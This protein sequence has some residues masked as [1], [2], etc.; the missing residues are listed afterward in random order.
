MKT[1]LPFLH[2]LCLSSLNGYGQI[3]QTRFERIDNF[4]SG[5]VYDIE[6]DSLGFLWFATVNGLFRYNGYNFKP[7]THND[8]DP[9]SISTSKVWAL[10]RDHKGGLWAG[11]DAG[12]D[13][14]DQQTYHFVHCGFT[15]KK[16]QK[17][18]T[19]I[20][21]LFEDSQNRF[22]IG[23][24]EGIYQYKGSPLD[25]TAQPI[26]YQETGAWAGQVDQLLVKRFL[27]DNA[28]NLWAGAAYGL[29]RINPKAST[30]TRHLP[31]YMKRFN[32]KDL[33]NT[34]AL[35]QD[36]S[37]KI[38][39]ASSKGLF[40]WRPAELRLEA[41]PLP[42][43]EPMAHIMCLLTDRSGYLWIGTK[44]YGLLRLHLSSK[45]I[46][47]FNYSANEPTSIV[48]R[49]IKSLLFDK[50]GSLWIG[51][52]GGL[53][54]TNIAPGLEYYTLF[55]GKE[56]VDNFVL[57]ILLDPAGSVWIRRRDIEIWH[58]PRLGEPLSK[59]TRTGPDI[60]SADSISGFH[61]DRR[62]GL[63]I[64]TMS[65]RLFWYSVTDKKLKPIPLA[66]AL[67]NRS[68]FALE[69]DLDDPN[70]TWVCGSR[71]LIRYNHSGDSVKVYSLKKIDPDAKNK[72][73]K[74]LIQTPD[75]KVWFHGP[76]FGLGF[77]DKSADTLALYHPQ[78]AFQI[79]K[80]RNGVV[81]HQG[82]LWLATASGLIK[83]DP[84]SGQ[85]T[86][87]ERAGR[88]IT[89][90]NMSSI[91]VDQSGSLWF[92]GAGFISR[93]DPKRDSFWHI[94]VSNNISFVTNSVCTAPDGTIF[95][96]GGNGF[97]RILPSLLRPNS[98]PPRIVLSEVKVFNQTKKLPLAPELT[99]TLEFEYEENLITLNFVALHFINSRHNRYKYRLE[100][101]NRD[102]IDA[103]KEPQATF[104]NL[105]PGRY[106][107][108]VR[109][110]N[111][112]GI[113]TPED[114][115]SVVIIIHPPWYLTLWAFLAYIALILGA[116]FGLY[117][118][119]LNR[120]LAAAETSRLRELDQVKTRL[121]TNITHEFRTP[122]TVILGE[123]EQ[124]EKR[125]TALQRP[126][127]TAIR[128]Q[129]RQ[130][131]LLVNQM[132][133]LAK[134]E[135]GS[136]PLHQIQGNVVL[137]LKYVLESFYS[138]ALGKQIE[139]R[140]ESVTTEFWMDYDPDK[141]QKIAANL[142][143][144]A[145]KFTPPGGQVTLRVHTGESLQFVVI[146][147][148]Q[149]IPA[150]KL[151]F[152]FDR[153]YQA[154]DTAIRPAE[155]TGIGLTLTKELVRLFGGTIQVESRPGEGSTFS[156]LLPVTRKATRQLLDT[157]HLSNENRRTAPSPETSAAS[158]PGGKTAHS[159]AP[160]LLII[161][162]NADVVRYLSALLSA[163]YQIYCAQNGREGVEAAL[164]RVPDL[165]ISDVMMPEMDG[166]EV[167]RTLKTDARTSHIPIVLLTAKADL[168]SR[169]EGL[170]QGADAYLAKP[171]E[172]RELKVQLRKLHELRQALRERYAGSGPP[173]PAPTDPPAFRRE[174]AFF[175]KL[176]AVLESNFQKAAFG[177]PELCK[178]MGMSRTSLY[179][180]LIALTGK[181]IE[182]HLRGFRLA[183]ARELL[184]TTDRSIK[185]IAWDCGFND[186]AHF[187][188]SFRQEFG[189]A[190]GEAR[191]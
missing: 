13:Y 56:T 27:E 141:L 101:F 175:R 90:R 60:A 86:P 148:G 106:V 28:G 34:E 169:I 145:L 11:T 77:L 130:L 107:F 4:H 113:W 115:W 43:E 67:R 51:A 172:E 112:D 186:Q 63:W 46:E 168:D 104:T 156:V 16:R 70:I 71:E 47:H 79:G 55:P 61:P 149:G 83:I 122:L 152:V 110:A 158:L 133:D 14:F 176:N 1:L 65:G 108:R 142:L 52:Y 170:E 191:S 49:H 180:K 98:T 10:L 119:L 102:W 140:F 144:N 15:D 165:I 183:K 121:Y 134:V 26:H 154:D 62:D 40:L 166:F 12:L 157:D 147:T 81:D 150:D 177:V 3:K 73:A 88:Q 87:F 109:A 69:A 92:A 33:F 131:L 136:L 59:I 76:H 94:D 100:G 163:E 44:K 179:R 151:P 9:H 18:I 125:A 85:L 96:G 22:W 173:A 181:N 143:S 6:E 118:F 64:V 20:K 114:A 171:F 155:G 137:F 39:V 31:E 124:L 185:E 129:G 5:Q 159:D 116:L 50:M 75:G 66:P 174:D 37:G 127:L 80:I 120:K 48:D 72:L 23:G 45:K 123:T 164:R 167:C 153:F 42:L 17:R 161:E 111:S 7:F 74:F 2:L 32:A 54:K 95:F 24:Q 38:W 57:G 162:D 189:M 25:S 8:D 58:A 132:L 190:P 105:N 30:F 97:C 93:Y 19:T 103:G 35:V 84:R 139:L 178:A 99:K 182:D 160:Q 78:P 184:Q 36:D 135:A 91:A 188:R 126:G 117:R 128:K 146:D 53:C 21:G 29:L 89:G 41:F 138:L 187:S 82:N 68:V